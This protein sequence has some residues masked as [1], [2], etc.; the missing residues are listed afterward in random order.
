MLARTGRG[1]RGGGGE[2]VGR[3]KRVGC[4]GRWRRTTPARLRVPGATR[5]IGVGE[6]IWPN[7]RNP[8]SA[9]RLI[10]HSLFPLPWSALIVT[11]RLPHPH[12]VGW[13]A[14]P[15]GRRAAVTTGRTRMDGS[16]LSK[17]SVAIPVAGTRSHHTWPCRAMRP[18]F[19]TDLGDLCGPAGCSAHRDSARITAS[20]S[21][22]ARRSTLP[23]CVASGLPRDT[24]ARS[25]SAGGGP[26]ARLGDTLLGRVW[27]AYLQQCEITSWPLTTPHVTEIFV[28][29]TYQCVHS[30]GSRRNSPAWE[31]RHAPLLP[32]LPC[33]SLLQPTASAGNL[34]GV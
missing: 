32:T 27:F 33:R 3:A 15:A 29:N 1:G 4:H 6:G 30:W 26:T 2:Q 31:T 9:F 10:V 28:Q 18:S 22:A 19:L 25:G 23:G 8:A 17:T 11:V 16:A 21:A 14:A 13:P 24:P 34:R 20:P 12:P 5:D 7:E